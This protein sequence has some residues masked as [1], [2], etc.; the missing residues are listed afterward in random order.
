MTYRTYTDEV[1]DEVVINTDGT[2]SAAYVKSLQSKIE[3]VLNQS[4]T[5]EGEISSAKCY[6]DETQNVLSTNKVEV[7]ISILPVGYAKEINV[8]L[9]FANPQNT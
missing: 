1:N 9:G 3:T 7:T 8:K 2:L 5:A 6:I 4:M